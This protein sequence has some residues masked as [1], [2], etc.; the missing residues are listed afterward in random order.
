[1]PSTVTDSFDVTLQEKSG[2][3]YGSEKLS[4]VR[5]NLP[6]AWTTVKI[7]SAE[8]TPTAAPSVVGSVALNKLVSSDKVTGEN[9]ANN[10][11]DYRIGIVV[12]K[13]GAEAEYGT[14]LLLSMAIRNLQKMNMWVL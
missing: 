3:S 6:L 14:D 13:N 1:M 8:P 7:S 10:E 12:T 2:I 11:S 5:N 9:V 4:T